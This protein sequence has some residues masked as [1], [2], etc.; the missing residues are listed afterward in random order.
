MVANSCPKCGKAMVEDFV[1]DTTHGGSDAVAH[2][3]PG[4]PVKSIWTGIKT[5]TAER[6][7]IRSLRCSGC[8]FLEHYA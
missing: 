7:P 8:G 5:T 3:Y 4:K 1:L 2:W 6:R